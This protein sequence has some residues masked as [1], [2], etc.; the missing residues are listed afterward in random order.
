MARPKTIS[1]EAILDA[2]LDQMLA[3]GPSNL[4][5]AQAGKA[6][7]LSP[8][9]LVQRYGDKDTLIEAALLH[10]WDLLDQA[11]ARA[12]L[13]EPL[14]PEGA[15]RVLLRL[16]NRENPEQNETDG[17]LILREDIRNPILRTRG[18][19]WGAALAAALGRRLTDDTAKATSFGWQMAEV[20]MGARIWWAFTRTEPFDIAI[21]RS[22][23]EWCSA[24]TRVTSQ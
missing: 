8:A 23:K 3:V 18:A 13:E 15:I 12:D 7:G 5:L 11:T 4:T 2:V 20:W 10:A 17:L 9:T 16:V 21:R 6:A 19:T 22:L 1:D 24:T 14:T